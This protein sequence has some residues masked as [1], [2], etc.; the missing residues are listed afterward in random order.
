MTDLQITE[1]G[2]IQFPMVQHAAEIGW[3]AI[4]PQQAM[5]KRG[6]AA[7]MLFRDDLG[8]KLA[9]LNPWM[10]EIAVRQVIERLEAIPPSI[11]GNREVLAWLRGERQ[12][13]DEAEERNRR[14]RLVDF[15]RP[16]ANSLHVELIA[17][18]QLFNVTHL[19]EY[20][21]GVTWNA[22]RRFMARWKE[23]GRAV[24]RPPQRL[25]RSRQV[26]GRPRPQ[27]PRAGARQR[28]PG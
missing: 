4:S 27:D 13:Y 7:G 18:P 28:H 25:R 17:A 24:H 10:S 14:V 26:R 21:Y 23:A 3:T 8:A 16:A 9:Q 22:T 15:E 5:R 11:E 12:V 6:S 20:W 19:L 2:S 1:A